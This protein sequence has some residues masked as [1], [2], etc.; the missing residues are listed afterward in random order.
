M[1]QYFLRGGLAYYGSP[2]GFCENY[3]SVKKVAFGVG[4]AT[5]E[6][7]SWDFAYELTECTSGYT[8][9]S[10]YENDVNIAGDV[11]QRKWRNKLM[12]T[13]KMRFE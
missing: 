3:G 2:Y 13:L 1:R 12:V 11:I 6:V 9:Y 4:Y 10:Y 8:P 5:S 7:T